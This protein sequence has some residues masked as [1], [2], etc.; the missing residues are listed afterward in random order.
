MSFRFFLSP[1]DG[2]ISVNKHR[3][4]HI[5]SLHSTSPDEPI[6][7]SNVWGTIEYMSLLPLPLLWPARSRDLSPIENI[8]SMVAER[9]AY[10]HKPVTTVDELSHRVETAWAVLLNMATNLLDSMPR[11]IT[12]VIAARESYS[13][14]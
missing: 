2:R 13:G 14:Y 12:A 1:Q 7:W 5:A 8:Q 3:G 9:L 6:I 4:M 11:H 10:H